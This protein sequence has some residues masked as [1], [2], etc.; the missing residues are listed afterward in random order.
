K[1][2]GIR[3][4]PL[5][6]MVRVP[7]PALGPKVSLLKPEN[8]LR[9][10]ALTQSVPAPGAVVPPNTTSSAPCE[11]G[12]T[13]NEPLPEMVPVPPV[14]LIVSASRVRL[15]APAVIVPTESV[16][17]P[18]S[19]TVF[20]VNVAGLVTVSPDNAVVPPTLPPKV[21]AAPL[22]PPTERPTVAPDTA[23]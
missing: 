18:A 1:V 22:P 2:V 19:R 8:T 21:T 10:V 15:C 9:D 23:S 4:V 20:D 16:P 12:S 17:V 6:L 11:N 14:R 5:A 3:N 7:L 13:V